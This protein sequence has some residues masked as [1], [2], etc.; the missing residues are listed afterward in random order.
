MEVAPSKPWSR[1]LA[2]AW[3]FGSKAPFPKNSSD[4]IPFWLPNLSRAYRS[5]SSAEELWSAR[6]RA[7]VEAHSRAH[8][9]SAADLTGPTEPKPPAFFLGP[10]EAAGLLPPIWP[11]P[12]LPKPMP[13]RSTSAADFC[14][15]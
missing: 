6:S 3:A 11:N 12:S 10:A 1:V 5:D 7:C 2:S 9:P 15:E 13:S 14:R 4:D 8:S